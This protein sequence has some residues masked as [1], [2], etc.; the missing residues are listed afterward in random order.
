MVWSSGCYRGAQFTKSRVEFSPSGA[1][2]AAT[3]S[4]Y[5]AVC[6][7][8]LIQLY[9]VATG[10]LVRTLEGHKDVVTSALFAIGSENANKRLYSSS[11]DG[12]IKLWNI[13]ESKILEVRLI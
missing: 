3:T 13:E 2:G 1:E 7:G 9:A 4:K 8:N 10:E 12:T 5:F 11:K 6:T